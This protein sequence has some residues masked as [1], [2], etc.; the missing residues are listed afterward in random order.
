V[1]FGY[2]VKDP[3]RYGVVEFDGKGNVLSIEEKPEYPVYVTFFAMIFNIVLNYFMIL[4]W[5]IIGAG[6]ATV[7]A[8]TFSWIVLGYLSKTLFNVFPKLRYF[9]KPLGASIIMYYLYLNLYS[10]F[11]YVEAVIIGAIVYFIILLM[12]RGLT[13]DDFRYIMAILGV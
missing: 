6:I 13:K 9:I 3:S 5:R 11:N 12:F 7:I 2:Y 1:I 4:K 8:N 10:L